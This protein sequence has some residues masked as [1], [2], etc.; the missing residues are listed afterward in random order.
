MLWV[1]LCLQCKCRIVLVKGSSS[2]FDGVNINVV[3]E[4][5]AWLLI[6]FSDFKIMIDPN[7]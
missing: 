6:P 4:I 3:I 5:S 1:V 2:L 7:T